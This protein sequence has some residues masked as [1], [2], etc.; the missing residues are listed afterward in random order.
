[1][2]QPLLGTPEGIHSGCIIIVNLTP[3]NEHMCLETQDTQE[4][5]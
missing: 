4:E 2:L 1:M 3:D 5:A